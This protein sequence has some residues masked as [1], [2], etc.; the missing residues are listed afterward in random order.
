MMQAEQMAGMD[1]DGILSSFEK[2]TAFI[3]QG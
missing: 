2:E 1:G 3:G